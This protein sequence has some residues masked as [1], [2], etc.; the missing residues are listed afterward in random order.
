MKNLFLLIPFA[1]MSL[2]ANAQTDESDYYFKIKWQQLNDSTLVKMP[3]MDIYVSLN[4]KII[5]YNGK[6][7]QFSNLYTT[8]YL[9]STYIQTDSTAVIISFSKAENSD[10]RHII[11]I[12]EFPNVFDSIKSRTIVKI[13]EA[14]RVKRKVNLNTYRN[15]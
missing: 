10:G 11:G 1:I 5:V 8:D 7:Y 2:I 9:Y 15:D 13:Y 4:E 12:D 6:P 14:K 3:Q